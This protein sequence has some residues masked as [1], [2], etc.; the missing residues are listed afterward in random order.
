M[1][2]CVSIQS[3]MLPFQE[4]HI[5]LHTLQPPQIQSQ[6]I[7]G[8]HSAPGGNLTLKLGRERHNSLALLLPDPVPTVARGNIMKCS[9]RQIKARQM[10]AEQKHMQGICG[11]LLTNQ[12]PALKSSLICPAAHQGFIS[13]LHIYENQRVRRE[14]R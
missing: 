8:S 6:F 13:S 7:F 12:D 1:L 11:L 3:K 5:S 4:T 14:K 10:C 9:L 2:N